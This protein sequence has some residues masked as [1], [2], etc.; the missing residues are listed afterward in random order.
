M[1]WT[2]LSRKT[3]WTPRRRSPPS[4]V[5]NVTSTHPDQVY[6]GQLVLSNGLLTRKTKQLTIDHF[7]ELSVYY[8]KEMTR[9]RCT[10]RPHHCPTIATR[11][12]GFVFSD[13]KTAILPVSGIWLSRSRGIL[14]LLPSVITRDNLLWFELIDNTNWN[15]NIHVPSANHILRRLA[16]TGF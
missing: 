1:C 15:D 8:C 12:S 6:S 3:V 5:T 14:P 7:T 9:Y 2:G 4:V 13:K 11:D 16:I 10:H